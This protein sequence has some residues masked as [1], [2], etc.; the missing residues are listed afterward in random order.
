MCEPHRRTAAGSRCFPL[1]QLVGLPGRL[2]VCR[3]EAFS[4]GVSVSV[5]VCGAGAGADTIAW[6]PPPG[7]MPG[8]AAAHL[9]FL[10]AV[11]VAAQV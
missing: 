8:A 6:V 2:C 7:T 4:A 11:E 9:G 1:Q 5:S 10:T 3:V